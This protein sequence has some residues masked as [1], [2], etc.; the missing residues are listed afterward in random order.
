MKFLELVHRLDNNRIIAIKEVEISQELYLKLPLPEIK[1]LIKEASTFALINAEGVKD[2]E[3]TIIEA[4]MPL[5]INETLDPAR[6]KLSADKTQL[7]NYPGYKEVATRLQELKDA[8]LQKIDNCTTL[9]ELKALLKQQ[10]ED[11]FT[12]L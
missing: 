4:S 1:A 12:A 2:R 8:E 6:Y 9:A 11:S 10:I 5:P 3:L 7:E